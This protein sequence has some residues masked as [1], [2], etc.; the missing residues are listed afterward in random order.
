MKSPDREQHQIGCPRDLSPGQGPL[1][2]LEVRGV[3]PKG[4]VGGDVDVEMG[5]IVRSA[6]RASVR[7][8]TRYRLVE[9]RDGSD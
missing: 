5:V 3:S 9:D 7:P 1:D 4:G 8:R 2:L 6:L